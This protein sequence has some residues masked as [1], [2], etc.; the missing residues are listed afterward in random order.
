MRQR[1][2][3]RHHVKWKLA[4]VIALKPPGAFFLCSP[5]TQPNLPFAAVSFVDVTVWQ[6]F[7][8]GA[9]EC[10][11]SPQNV[12]IKQIHLLS[13]CTIYWAVRGERA[14]K[15]TN[16]ACQVGDGEGALWPSISSAS[17]QERNFHQTWYIKEGVQVA[18]GKQHRGS[19]WQKVLLTQNQVLLFSRKPA[20]RLITAT[21][22]LCF[23]R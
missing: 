3:S 5:L 13:I 11:P 20:I 10:Y 15:A 18:H 12:A 8:P 17:L 19:A 7:T 9:A 16:R 22:R 21:P 14:C 2:Q 23:F 6:T 4:S 1:Q